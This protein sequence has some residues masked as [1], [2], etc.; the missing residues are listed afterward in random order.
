MAPLSPSWHIPWQPLVPR[1]TCGVMSRSVQWLQMC[2]WSWHLKESPYNRRGRQGQK[3]M[4]RQ[5]DTRTPRVPGQSSG[6]GQG[7]GKAS[8][9]PGLGAGVGVVT[10]SDEPQDARELFLHRLVLDGDQSL[11]M[12]ACKPRGAELAPGPHPTVGRGQ[13]PDQGLTTALPQRS[14]PGTRSPPQKA[15]RS[16]E[17]L[18]RASTVLGEGRLA[19]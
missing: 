14:I 13:S 12:G 19:S 9:E 11:L 2:L 10:D 5:T 7:F 3:Y 16:A 18:G 15:L 1:R 6:Q 4:Y 17:F 8:P